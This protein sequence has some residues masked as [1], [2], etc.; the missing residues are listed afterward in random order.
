MVVRQ[1]PLASS[2]FLKSKDTKGAMLINMLKAVDSMLLEFKQGEGV[3]NTE[4]V[5]ISVSCAKKLL[6]EIIQSLESEETYHPKLVFNKAFPHGDSPE[7]EGKPKAPANSAEP[8]YQASVDTD[9]KLVGIKGLD[10]E[11]KIE[12]DGKVMTHK[13]AIGKKFGKVKIL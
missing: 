6:F 13:E 9:Q 2:V 4:Q 1:S 5:F 3:D 10:L 8:L 11:A 7:L 12:L